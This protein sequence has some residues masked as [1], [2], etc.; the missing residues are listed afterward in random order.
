[1]EDLV[2]EIERTACREGAARVIKVRV[3]LGALSHLTPEHFR[4][5]FR[6]A[7]QGTVAEGAAVEAEVGTDVG[8]QDADRVVLQALEVELP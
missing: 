8:E 1:M 2:S 6:E 7:A 4:A 3:R 5:H